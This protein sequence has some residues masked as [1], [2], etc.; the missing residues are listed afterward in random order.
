MSEHRKYN[1]YSNWYR[2]GMPP[3]CYFWRTYQQQEIDYVEEYDGNL[4][5]YEFKWN[6]KAKTRFPK[7][8]IE[9][10]PHASTEVITLDNFSDFVMG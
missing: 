9:A 1:A 10:Y 2:S 3:R 8:F 5:A 4:H 6:P 7:T